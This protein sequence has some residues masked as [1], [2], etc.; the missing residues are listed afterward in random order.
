M[1]INF[2]NN[3]LSNAKTLINYFPIIIKEAKYNKV[4]DI[5]NRLYIICWFITIRS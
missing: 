1:N 2:F 4:I 5:N 3:K